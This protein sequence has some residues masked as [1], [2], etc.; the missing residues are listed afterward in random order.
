MT[1]KKKEEKEDS[2]FEWEETKPDINKIQTI[3]N[4]VKF[5]KLGTTSASKYL[6][7]NLIATVDPYNFVKTN[8]ND[9]LEDINGF[10]KMIV[11]KLS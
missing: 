9:L 5:N 7:Q 4:S 1:A 3:D 11:S 2:D 10:V 8:F 6:R